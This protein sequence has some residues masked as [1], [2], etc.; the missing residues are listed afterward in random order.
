[1][2]RA[3]RIS[4]DLIRKQP[5]HTIFLVT[6]VRKAADSSE[7]PEPTTEIKYGFL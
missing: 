1:M 6:E 2:F 5:T 7:R 3:A 4:R